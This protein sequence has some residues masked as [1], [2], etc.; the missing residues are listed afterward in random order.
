M[1]GEALLELAGAEDSSIELLR[2]C[3]QNT[4]V[5]YASPETGDT[6]LHLAGAA[7]NL[8]ACRVLTDLGADPLKRNKRNRTPAAQLKLD[9]EVKQFLS[10]VEDAATLARKNKNAGIWDDKIRATQTESALRIGVL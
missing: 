10:E 4:D 6:A 1:D 7:G 9:P 2:G 8:E 5:N 3:A